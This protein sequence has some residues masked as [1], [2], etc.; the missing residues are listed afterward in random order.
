MAY[1]LEIISFAKAVVYFQTIVQLFQTLPTYKWLADAGITPSHHKT[2]TESEILDALKQGSGVSSGSLGYGAVHGL[3]LLQYT[4]AVGCSH[5]K[6]DAIS[7]YF[8]LKGSLLDGEFIPIGK[9]ALTPPL[10]EAC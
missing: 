4:P 3:I 1:C 2:Y 8:N 6:L 9:C 7:W 5:G 10:D